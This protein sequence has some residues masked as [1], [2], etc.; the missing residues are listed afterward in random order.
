[1]KINTVLGSCDPADLGPTLVHEHLMTGMPGGDLDNPNFD[2]AREFGKVVG[3]V[4]KVKQRGIATLI[5]PCPMD[6]GRDPE[7]AAAVSDRTGMR[8]IMSTGLY[9]DVMGIPTHFRMQDAD[10]IAELYVREITEGIGSTGIKAGL[11]KTANS[12]VRRSSGGKEPHRRRREGLQGRGPRPKGD[13]RADPGP[14]QRD[15]AA[16]PPG[17]GHPRR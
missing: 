4:E 11:I 9:N 16:G 17:A 7:F 5:D 2:R 12:G 10:D 13:R 8:V 3:A 6:L 1:M 14:Q 15:F